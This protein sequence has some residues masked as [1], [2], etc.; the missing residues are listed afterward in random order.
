M[1]D[2]GSLTLPEPECASFAIVPA[3]KRDRVLRQSGGGALGGRRSRSIHHQA[4]NDD[5]NRGEQYR[6]RHTAVLNKMTSLGRPTF[7]RVS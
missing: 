6:E 7:E 1:T 2:A 5:C 4:K 3:N